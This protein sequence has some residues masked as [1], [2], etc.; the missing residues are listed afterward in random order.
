[1]SEPVDTRELWLIVVDRMYEHVP[2]GPEWDWFE[3]HVELPVRALICELKG[4]QVIDDQCGK[5]EH[6]FC[7][8]CGVRQP[9]AEVNV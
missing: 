2:E 7:T 8:V 1:M 4:H 9:N 5:P 3:E 6:R